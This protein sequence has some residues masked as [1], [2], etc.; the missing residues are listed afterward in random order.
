MEQWFCFFLC[1]L[2]TFQGHIVY[3]STSEQTLVIL[4]YPE[5]GINWTTGDDDGGTN[6]LGG[7][8]AIVG[9][10]SQAGSLLLPES[11]T[12]AI[13]DIESLTNVGIPGVFVYRVDADLLQRKPLSLRLTKHCTQV[14]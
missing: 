3:S 1:Q 7:T 9:L 6:G 11:L 12:P 5:N 2:N 13:V 8:Q 14:L 10:T 4:L